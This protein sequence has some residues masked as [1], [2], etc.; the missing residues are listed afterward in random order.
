MSPTA[1]PAIKLSIYKFVCLLIKLADRPSERPSACLE[2]V[3]SDT[4]LPPAPSGGAAGDSEQHFFFFPRD[5][6]RFGSRSLCEKYLHLWPFLQGHSV[7]GIIY[8]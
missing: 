4:R 6:T 8:L 7:S 1:L 5:S 2:D 3:L